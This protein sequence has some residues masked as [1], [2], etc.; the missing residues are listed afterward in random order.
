[1]IC[2]VGCE[3]HARISSVPNF[4][5]DS[6]NLRLALWKF[7][8]PSPFRPN[9]VAVDVHLE[10]TSNA[11]VPDFPDGDLAIESFLQLAFQPA[12]VLVVTSS[13]AVL[14]ID[15]QTFCNTC[16]NNIIVWGFPQSYCCDGILDF[17]DFFSGAREALPVLFGP[18]LFAVDKHLEITSFSRVPG[19]SD[20]DLAIEGVLQLLLELFGP[21]PIASSAAVL[22]M[23]VQIRDSGLDHCCCRRVYLDLNCVDDSLNIFLGFWE[24]LSVLFGPN[25]FAIDKHLEITSSPG[26]LD[27]SDRDLAVESLL[28][29]LFE[30]SRLRSIAS[31]ATVLD[32]DVYPCKSWITRSSIRFPSHAAPH[33]ISEIG[34]GFRTEHSGVDRQNPLHGNYQKDVLCRCHYNNF[35]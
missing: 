10:I 6:F 21:W 16:R 5:A 7:L 12:G 27:F 24:P 34:F 23:D 22:D 18:N 2:G 31:S 17:L 29:L 35:Q 33:R 20:R 15:I 1:M 13:A 8:S 28:Q 4:I 3:L 30:V 14:D 26:V 32:I 9:P 19:F 25:V 11:G